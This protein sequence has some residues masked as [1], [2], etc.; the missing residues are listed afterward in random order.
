LWLWWCIATRNSS[1]KILPDHIGPNSTATLPGKLREHP[2][3]SKDD[4]N[5][6]TKNYTHKNITH[7]L[8]QIIYKDC[9]MKP[10]LRIVLQK[11]AE[12]IRNSPHG[13]WRK[14]SIDALANR[15]SLQ[16]S[17]WAAS[18]SCSHAIAFNR[19]YSPAV[20]WMGFHL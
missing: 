9:S 14:H 3:P 13:Q 6:E 16:W 15:S 18:V 11:G 20:P 1:L 4:G 7:I 12:A 5:S 17:P 8:T 2:H 19:P 10:V